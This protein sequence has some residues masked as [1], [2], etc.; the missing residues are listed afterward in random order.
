MPDGYTA[1]LMLISIYN[2]IQNM[3]LSS[4]F[5][6]KFRWQVRIWLQE[7]V[8]G[9]PLGEAWQYGTSNAHNKLPMPK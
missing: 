8:S 9:K 5:R 7:R 6:Y 3:V 1:L 2:T 4:R